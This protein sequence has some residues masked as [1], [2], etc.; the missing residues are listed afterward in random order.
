MKTTYKR[1][2]GYLETKH[3]DLL[4]KRTASGGIFDAYKKAFELE[5]C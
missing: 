2:S 4:N 1:F 3:T 5:R